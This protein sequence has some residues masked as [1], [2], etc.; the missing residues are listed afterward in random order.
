MANPTIDPPS[1]TKQKSTKQK[2]SQTQS[3]TL[4][5][6]RRTRNSELSTKTSSQIQRSK[7]LH[8]QEKLC[9][10]TP[11]CEYT[12]LTFFVSRRQSRCANAMH[13]E[14]SQPESLVNATVSPSPPDLARVSADCDGVVDAKW[15]VT[16]TVSPSPPDQAKAT[17]DPPVAPNPTTVE[18]WLPTRAGRHLDLPYIHKKEAS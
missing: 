17:A 18:A 15:I 5:T 6:L 11:L 10:K 3:I 16:A 4:D 14:T 12:I 9:W 8:P 2:L 13:G 7:K 1:S